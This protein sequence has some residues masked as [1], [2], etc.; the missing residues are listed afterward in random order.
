MGKRKTMGGSGFPRSTSRHKLKELKYYS[1]SR[2]VF[3]P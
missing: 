1:R 3:L 2:F